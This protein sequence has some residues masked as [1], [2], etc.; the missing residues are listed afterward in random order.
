MS[1]REWRCRN[2]HCSVPHGAVLGRLSV[3]TSGLAVDPAVS[4]VQVYFDAG[5]AQIRCPVCG[6]PRDFRGLRI[7]IGDV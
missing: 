4:A 6:A 3:D 1:R 2:P 7:K 5:R